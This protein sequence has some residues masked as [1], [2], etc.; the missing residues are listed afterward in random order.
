MQVAIVGCGYVG[1]ELA[2]QLTKV[3]HEVVGVRRSDGGVTA[4]ADAG[5]DAVQADAT[6][7]DSLEAVPDVDVVVFAASSDGRD[8]D[9]AREIYVDGLRTT[10]EHFGARET[11]PD[12]FVYLSSTGVYGEQNGNWVDETTTLVPASSRGTVLADAERIAR[13]RP[14]SHGIDWTVVRLA[15]LY[16]PGRYRTDRYLDGPVDDGYLNMIH[17]AD[18]AGVVRF[19]L[20]SNEARNDLILAVDDEPVSRRAFAAWLT[21]RVRDEGSQNYQA[22]EVSE[23]ERSRTSGTQITVGKRCANNKLRGLGY[24]FKF[25]TYREGYQNAVSGPK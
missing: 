5:F 22:D 9:A 25:S 2:E 4:I 24:K 6:D 15:G 8:A 12:R 10:V 21:D 3:G 13:E 11:S 14:P 16:G 7:A 20:E 19:L 1:L 23:D 18:A 17:R